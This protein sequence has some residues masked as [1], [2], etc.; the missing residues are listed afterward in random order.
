MAPNWRSLTYSCNGHDDHDGHDGHDGCDSCDSCDSH[1]NHC[2]GHGNPS[3]KIN[4]ICMNGSS[5]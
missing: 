5:S 1:V 2:D 4:I 3:H